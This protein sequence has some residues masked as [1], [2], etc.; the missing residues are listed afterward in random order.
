MVPLLLLTLMTRRVLCRL[1]VTPLTLDT[2]VLFILVL[3]VRRCRVLLR[4]VDLI[5]LLFVVVGK[6]LSCRPLLVRLTMTDATK[7]VM[8]LINLQ[9]KMRRLL[10]LYVRRTVPS[11]CPR[12]SRSVTDLL[13]LVM[14]CRLVMM[15]ALILVT[16]VR[17]LLV[18]TWRKR[19][20][21]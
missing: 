9:V 15:T 10:L 18:R 20:V 1:F 2:V 13:R 6:V 12:L 7:L 5:Y 8:R 21:R 4:K 3:T 11:R 19:F 14:L 16:L 17:L